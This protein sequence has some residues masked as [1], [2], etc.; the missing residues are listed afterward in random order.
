VT[1]DA[2][3]TIG[4][5][6]PGTVFTLSGGI[7]CTTN[8][9][10]LTFKAIGD[11]VLTG[12][13]TN[14]GNVTITTGTVVLTSGGTVTISGALTN[15]GTLRCLSG[16]VL[17]P[18]DFF[19]NNGVLDLI[20]GNALLPTNFINHGVVLTA[21]DVRVAQCSPIGNDIVIRLASVMGHTY[22]LQITD[23]ITP[24]AWTNAGPS[25]AG[26]GGV[27]TFTDTGGLL[28]SQR[29]YRVAVGP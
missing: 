18:T 10:A 6:V 17:K 7:D 15:N 8:R 14:A 16:T 25:Q 24:P 26:T 1:L 23:T 5:A 9:F 28:R 2:D 29:F 21:S 20:N 19:I 13:L 3:A 27:L 12:L 22:Q 4:N 11:I